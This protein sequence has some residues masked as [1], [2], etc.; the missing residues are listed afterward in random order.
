MASDLIRSMSA[1]RV[2]DRSNDTTRPPAQTFRQAGIRGSF[3]L[4]IAPLA[5]NCQRAKEKP[6]N[7][8]MLAAQ[9]IASG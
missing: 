1:D 3:D 8:T 4:K 6:L 5:Q 9:W 7:S 2:D